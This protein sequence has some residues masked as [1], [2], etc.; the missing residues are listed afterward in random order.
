M[1]SVENYIYEHEGGP[2]A[3]MLHLHH[4]LVNLN[5]VPKIVFNLPFYYGKSWICYLRPLK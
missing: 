5:L 4:M 1:T 2:R 3:I